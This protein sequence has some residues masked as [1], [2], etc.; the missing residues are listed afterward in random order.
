MNRMAEKLF[1]GLCAITLLGLAFYGWQQ[2]QLRVTPMRISSFV[3][4]V[5]PQTT[6]L[7]K[8]TNTDPKT[9]M[10]SIL[11]EPPP[12]DLQGLPTAVLKS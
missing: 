3:E 4:T 7:F 1:Y 12:I 8:A 9:Y 5:S 2:S 6:T 11:E 10:P